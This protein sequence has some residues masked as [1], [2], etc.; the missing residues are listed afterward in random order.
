[1]D[2]IL[3]PRTAVLHTHKYYLFE[4][5]TAFELYTMPVAMYSAILNDKDIALNKD[6]DLAIEAWFGLPLYERVEYAIMS[7][8]CT[9]VKKVRINQE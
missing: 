5:K 9:H 4:T 1:M 2:D 6:K 3:A 8:N 7:C